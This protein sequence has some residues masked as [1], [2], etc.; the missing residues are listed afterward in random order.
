VL[1]V[2][3]ESLCLVLSIARNSH[4]PHSCKIVRSINT[5]ILRFVVFLND[6]VVHATHC[7]HK[8]SQSPSIV[9]R[10]LI[11]ELVVDQGPDALILM[12]VGSDVKIDQT[13]TFVWRGEPLI[14]IRHVP[15][16]IPAMRIHL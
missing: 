10:G 9:R 3:L 6:E 2:D 1:I 8:I 7:L 5:E 14:Q 13:L 15:H 4:Y 12:H 11:H 16:G